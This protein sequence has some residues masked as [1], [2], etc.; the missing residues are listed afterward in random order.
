M[1][2]GF[3]ILVAQGSLLQLTLAM[4]VSLLYFGVIL[5]LLPMHELTNSY[6]VSFTSLMLFFTYLISHQLKVEGGIIE[7]AF[8][9]GF[10]DSLILAVLFGTSIGVLA[11]GSLHIFCPQAEMDP[12]WKRA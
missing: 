12:S 4:V 8:E 1:L 11:V 5:L 10:G 6:F 2:N 7:V 3:L 9:L